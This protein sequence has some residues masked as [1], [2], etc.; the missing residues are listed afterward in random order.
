VVPA[1]QSNKRLQRRYA[2]SC[3]MMETQK[4]TSWF[5]FQKV[6]TIAAWLVIP[7]FFIMFIANQHLISSYPL[8]S[9]PLL[10]T[11]GEEVTLMLRNYSLLAVVGLS[12]FSLPRWQ[13]IAGIVGTLIFLFVYGRQ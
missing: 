7:A 4:S 5:W 3:S 8:P 12:V 6:R 9:V 1:T 2:S 10:K 13:S 11:R